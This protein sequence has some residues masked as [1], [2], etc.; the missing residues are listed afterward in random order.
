MNSTTITFIDINV[1]SH[2]AEELPTPKGKAQFLI[3]NQVLIFLQHGK[4]KN[5]REIKF[6]SIKMEDILK[7][8]DNAII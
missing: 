3:H 8:R 6:I 7:L 5:S 4:I 1:G 2:S